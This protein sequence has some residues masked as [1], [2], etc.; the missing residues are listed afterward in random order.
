[1]SKHTPVFPV[2]MIP[3]DNAGGYTEVRET[4]ITLRQ[5][6]A[7]KAMQGELAALGSTDGRLFD[8]RMKMAENVGC[9]LAEIV[10]HEAVAMA[11]ALIEA[12][13]TEQ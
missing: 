3:M 2:P 8:L 11:D 7:V 5:Y 9:S 13:E 6:A 1:M 4:G 10:A 12:L